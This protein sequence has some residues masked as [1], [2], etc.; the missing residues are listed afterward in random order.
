MRVTLLSKALVV[1]AYQ[2]KCELIAAHPDVTLT[3]LVPPAWGSQRLE[4]ADGAGYA[5]RAIPVCLGGHFHL[6]YYPTLAQALKQAQPDV[7][8]IDE[9][10]YNLATW[11]AARKAAKLRPRPRVL[12]FSWQNINRRYPPPFSWIERDVLRRADAAIAGSQEARAVWQTKGFSRPIHVIPQFG[13]D[14]TAFAPAPRRGDSDSFVIGYAGRLVREKGVDVLLHA[15]AQLPGRARL[16]VVGQGREADHLGTLA[17]RLEVAGR[18]SFRPPMPST[19]MPE[20]YRALDAFVLP[21]RTLPNWK[22]QF[23]RVL[24]EAMACGVPVIASRCGEAPNVVGDAGLTFDEEDHA[25]LAE[26]LIA[27]MTQPRLREVMSQR[28]R[29]RVLQH[30]TMRCVADQTVEVYRSLLRPADRKS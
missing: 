28:G 19:R 27:L 6:H 8:H 23:G 29:D 11:L 18:T 30:F 3:A 5:L 12:F 4:R 16:I 26:H 13:V 7:L 14:E 24:I 20:F 9:E 1:G 15:L 17:R 10:P 2:R 22:E 25:A 21:S